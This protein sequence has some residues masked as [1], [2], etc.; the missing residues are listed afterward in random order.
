VARAALRHQSRYGAGLNINSPGGTPVPD[1]DT[2]PADLVHLL[3]SRVGLA[4]KEIAD[5]TKE[6]AVSRL[7]SFWLECE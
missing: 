1:T 3:I 4:E 7:Q 2:L 5:M 6:Q